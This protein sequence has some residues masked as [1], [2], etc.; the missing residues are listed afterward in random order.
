MKRVEALQVVGEI[1]ADQWGLFT[2]QQADAAGVNRTTLTRLVSAGIVD[3]VARGVHLVVA[4]GTPNHLEEKSAW[5]RLA[6]SRRAWER[7]AADQDN[8]VLSHRTACVLHELGDIPAPQVEMTVPRRRT[9]R[10]PGIRLHRGDLARH[11][12]TTTHDGLPVT[13][14]ERTIKDLL[15]ARVDG[16]HLGG[17]L[18]D[19][20][21][22]RLVDVRR[23]LAVLADCAP[24]YG[25][26][27]N[28]GLRLLQHLLHQAGADSA[29]DGRSAV[30]M[31]GEPGL[32][33]TAT[34][35]AI[36]TQLAG[37][38]TAQ[39][40]KVRAAVNAAIGEPDENNPTPETER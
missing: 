28:D 3:H 19:A 16:G 23:L 33:A 32:E 13:T 20:L 17:V 35:Q 38:D 40:R 15:V 36:A 4:A 37:L 11:E 25:I 31:T 26:D 24:A 39:L 5:L 29:F 1:A 12:I 30:A 7:D 6:P 18:N 21:L 10:V 8:G 34:V 9:T 22:R 14:V 2:T 27:R